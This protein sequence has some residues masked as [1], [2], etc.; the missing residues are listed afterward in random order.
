MNECIV[1]FVSSAQLLKLCE[2]L[3]KHIHQQLSGFFVERQ[4]LALASSCGW[5]VVNLDFLVAP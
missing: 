1:L 2:D 3:Q 4:I 5:V